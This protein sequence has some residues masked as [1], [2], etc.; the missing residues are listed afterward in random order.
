MQAAAYWSASTH[1]GQ[2]GDAWAGDLLGGLCYPMAS[3]IVAYVWPVR[4][5]Q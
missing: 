1:P 3:E 4:G 2:P 5:G